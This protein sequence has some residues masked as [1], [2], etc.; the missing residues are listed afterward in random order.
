MLSGR[1]ILADTY[2]EV[3]VYVRVIRNP[4]YPSFTHGDL[5]FNISETIKLDTVF[6]DVNATDPDSV[7]LYVI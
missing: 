2:A 6:G 1:E 5:V 7:C 4:T 3:T